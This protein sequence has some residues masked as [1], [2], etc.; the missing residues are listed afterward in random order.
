[1]ENEDPVCQTIEDVFGHI[2]GKLFVQDAYIKC[3]VAA[4]STIL[5]RV[6]FD[7]EEVA[8]F[9]DAFRTTFKEEIEKVKKNNSLLDEISIEKALND[10]RK[11]P[12]ISFE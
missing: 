8:L 1:M 5:R 12:G 9:K 10:L 2:Y 7:E 4:Q 3:L 6:G 11:I